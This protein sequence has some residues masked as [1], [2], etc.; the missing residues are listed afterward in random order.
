MIELGETDSLL[1]VGGKILG[2]PVLKFPGKTCGGIFT[3]WG[4]KP[5][6]TAVWA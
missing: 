4:E 5:V 1:R 2:G 3:H 6:L